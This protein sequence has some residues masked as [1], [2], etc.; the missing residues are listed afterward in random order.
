MRILEPIITLFTFPLLFACSSQTDEGGILVPEAARLSVRYTMP[1]DAASRVVG[2][3]LQTGLLDS[4][5]RVGLF[6]LKSDNSFAFDNLKYKG[7][8][9]FNNLVPD[10]GTTAPAAPDAG[11]QVIAC[12]PYGD[13]F[14]DLPET[15]AFQVQTDQSTEEGYLNSDLL[16]GE[17]ATIGADGA[18]VIPMKRK[19]CRC[20][21]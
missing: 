17:A 8:G 9:Q 16:W 15:S 13:G 1:P 6:G 7:N 2:H 14:K 11:T 18:A 4:R 12:A 21:R 19:L 10:D 20:S 5:T 3:S